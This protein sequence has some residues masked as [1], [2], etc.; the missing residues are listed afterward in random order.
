MSKKM[1]KII[2][3]ALAIILVPSTIVPAISVML[4]G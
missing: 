2:V 4:G 3:I 1:Q